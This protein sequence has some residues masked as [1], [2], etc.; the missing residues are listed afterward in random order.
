MSTLQ[1]QLA[2]FKEAVIKNCQSDTFPYREWFVDDHLAIVER[3]AMELC[4]KY[5]EADRDAVFALVWFHDFG[6][7]IDEES[8]REI[9]RTKGPETMTKLGFSTPFIEKVLALWERQEMKETIDISKEPIEVQII[10]TADG[11]SHFVG[12]FFSSYF[13]D[14][15]KESLKATVERLRAKMKKD[16]ER[17][18]VLPEAK[19]AFKH[20]YE[21]ALEIVGE[22]PKKFLN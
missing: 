5:P 4:D 8:E 21:H 9:T 17:K 7:P 2:A 20:R 19:A 18:I 16:W 15:P 12:K 14:E 10:S 6:K 1:P 11:A 3:I 13:S 22:Y